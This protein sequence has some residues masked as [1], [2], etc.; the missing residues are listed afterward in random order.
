M[1]TDVG[2]SVLMT[3]DINVSS[4]F[5]GHVENVFCIFCRFLR[6]ACKSTTY[7][8]ILE[9]QGIFRMWTRVWFTKLRRWVNDP[10]KVRKT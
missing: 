6:Y 5:R 2:M 10:D 4:S 9:R 1:K 7:I 3:D 8:C